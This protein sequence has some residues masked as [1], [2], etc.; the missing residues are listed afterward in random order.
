MLFFVSTLKYLKRKKRKVSQF[1]QEI[2]NLKIS[3]KMRILTII[4]FGILTDIVFSTIGTNQNYNIKK[5]V[6]VS[7]TYGLPCLIES[8]KK[9]SFLV[10]L[11]SCNSNPN[12]LAIIFQKNGINISSANCILY[13]K[14]F[15]DIEL[16]GSMGSDLYEKIFTFSRTELN[17]RLLNGKYKIHKSRT[18]YLMKIQYSFNIWKL[19]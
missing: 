13:S 5:N 2:Q 14:I 7:P 15:Q 6:Q 17:G 8:I 3:A 9:L 19:E 11:A 10:C 18:S 16:A 1:K 12:C 4:S